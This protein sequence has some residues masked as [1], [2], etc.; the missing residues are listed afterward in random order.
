[1]AWRT[2]AG[3]DI[4]VEARFGWNP[5]ALAVLLTEIEARY[6]PAG[7]SRQQ[8]QQFRDRL[9]WDDLLLARACARGDAAAWEEF[10]HKYQPGLRS[11]ARAMTRDAVRGEELADGLIGDL[12]GL[13]LRDGERCS[14]LKS[15]MGLGSLEGWLRALLAQAHVDEWR[16]RRR[17]TGLDESE[18]LQTLV[19][20]PH[21]APASFEPGA[22]E[23]SAAIGL[24]QQLEGAIESVLRSLDAAGRLLLNLYFLDGQTL[25]QIA[26]LLG[27][28]ESTVSRRLERQIGRLRK[29]L[30]RELAR[31][32]LRPDATEA[33][34]QLKPEW[35][36]VDVRKSLAAIGTPHHGE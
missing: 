20:F 26:G 25:A 31:Q 1:M 5:E 11:S 19:T 9:H 2:T 35:L 13:R 10:C 18:P 36:N 8:K 28:H 23:S 15:Y 34:M 27:V 6:L 12:F 16:Q 33:A 4:A 24:R 22:E 14:K 3:K 21:P 30:R 32:G 17:W 7:A 29:Q